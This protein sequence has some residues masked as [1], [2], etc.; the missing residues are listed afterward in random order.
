[1]AGQVRQPVTSGTM[2]I[3]AVLRL[4]TIWSSRLSSPSSRLA[5]QQ[6]LLPQPMVSCFLDGDFL[7]IDFGLVDHLP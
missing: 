2:S 7:M 5:A 3:T 1:M 6:H 4:A